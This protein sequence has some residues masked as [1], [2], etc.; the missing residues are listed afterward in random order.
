M[1]LKNQ[2]L[3]AHSKQNCDIIVNWVGNSQLRFDELFALFM[4][5]DK[6]LVQVSSWPLSYCVEAYPFLIKKHIA[7]FFKNL[8][9]PFAHEAVKR[10][11]LRILQFITI[12][13]KYEGFVMNLCFNFI[14]DITEKPAAKVF[15]LIVL[16]NLQKQYP[17]IKEELHLI[18]QTQMPF[19]SAGFR[20]RGKKMLK[21]GC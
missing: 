13:K 12:P 1:D 11:S 10:H 19:E 2:L 9:K 16:E 4:C 7:T 18:I 20:S 5:S 6:R 3:Q 14:Q 17:E 15:S 21:R 8:D